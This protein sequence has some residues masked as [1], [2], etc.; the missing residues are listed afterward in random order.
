MTT[1]D[2]DFPIRGQNW[3]SFAVGKSKELTNARIHHYA[4]QGRYGTAHQ[5]I[6]RATESNRIKNRDRRN[7]PHSRKHL[8]AS[9][10]ADKYGT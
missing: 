8:S 10:L 7:S 2:S 1:S 3:D 5:R 4:L 6:A 9:A